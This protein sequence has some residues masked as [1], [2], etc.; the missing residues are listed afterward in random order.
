MAQELGMMA[1]DSFHQFS[2]LQFCRAAGSQQVLCLSDL[3]LLSKGRS[4]QRMKWN[5]SGSQ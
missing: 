3:C 1:F 4:G 2:V 5:G